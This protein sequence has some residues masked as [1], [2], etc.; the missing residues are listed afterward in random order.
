MNTPTR[1]SRQ[2]SLRTR[3]TLAVL[4]AGVGGLDRAARERIVASY[5]DVLT[6]SRGHA[7]EI[8]ELDGVDLATATVVLRSAQ[9]AVHDD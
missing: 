1:I 9:R 7:G 2:L 8:A 5:G 6:L 3:G 4:L